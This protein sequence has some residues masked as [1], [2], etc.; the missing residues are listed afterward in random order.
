MKTITYVFL[1]LIIFSIPAHAVN[2]D[3]DFE[4]SNGYQWD[5]TCGCAEADDLGDCET[6]YPPPPTN[7][8]TCDVTSRLKQDFFAG[9]HKFYVSGPDAD[10]CSDAGVNYFTVG[11]A[12]FHRKSPDAS[13]S[14]NF[15]I[16]HTSAGQTA[17]HQ[18]HEML[19]SHDLQSNVSSGFIQVDFKYH[20]SGTSGSPC[21]TGDRNEHYVLA[22]YVDF[23]TATC[24]AKTCTLG[25]CIGNIPCTTDTTNCP[26]TNT[27]AGCVQD[28]TFLA[29]I[30]G[31]FG[32]NG[33]P[34]S[35]GFTFERAEQTCTGSPPNIICART[36]KLGPTTNERIS[37]TGWY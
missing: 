9:S 7:C 10:G 33:L 24:N 6:P 25:N 36:V 18:S 30:G 28:H 31:S 23:N 11:G 37:Y 13:P 15:L 12:A 3:D 17:K 22:T 2:F 35:C 27:E 34:A 8:P 19:V 32:G 1:L 20:G 5:L 16:A 26:A 21:T 29:V 4:T 14:E